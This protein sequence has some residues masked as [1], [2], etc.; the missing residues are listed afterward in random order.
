MTDRSWTGTSAP[1]RVREILRLFEALTE[2]AD[3]VSPETASTM[4]RISD[5]LEAV[6]VPY[7][8]GFS[9]R[10][11]DGTRLTRGWQSVTVD[12]KWRPPE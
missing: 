9:V 7:L 5:R 2:L 4:L 6:G 10:Y 8:P 1:F 3:Q 12:S 11:A